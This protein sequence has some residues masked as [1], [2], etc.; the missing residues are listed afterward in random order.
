[1]LRRI[2]GLLVKE[3]I[4]VFR[5]ART[6]TLLFVPPII[7]MLIFGYAATLEVRHIPIAVLDYDNSQVSRELLSRFTASPYLDVRTYLSDRR[8]IGDLIDSVMRNVS[9]GANLREIEE[10]VSRTACQHVGS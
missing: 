7:Q 9:V 1:M 2:H 6:R 3:F 8:E 10:V 5:D 4:Q